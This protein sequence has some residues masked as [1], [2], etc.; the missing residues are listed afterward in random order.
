M[1]ELKKRISVT[2]KD[3]A[4]F[5][6]NYRSQGK[7]ILILI[8]IFILLVSVLFYSVVDR[9]TL[10]YNSIPFMIFLFVFM[11]GI[12]SVVIWGVFFLLKLIRITFDNWLYKRNVKFKNAEITIN[13]TGIKIENEKNSFHVGWNQ[14]CKISEDKKRFYLYHSKNA[15]F[16]LPKRYI[17]SSEELFYLREFLEEMRKREI[18]ADYN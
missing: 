16:I 12:I 3:Y 9:S 14:I 11:F 4:G 18:V 2:A 15:A 1:F 6:K 5:N 10:K 7:I 8:W 17:E 13:N